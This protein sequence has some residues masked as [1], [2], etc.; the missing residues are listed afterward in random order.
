MKDSET[1]HRNL[2]SGLRGVDAV[3]YQ[4]GA[5]RPCSGDC[6]A[7][8][9]LPPSRNYTL[10]AKDFLPPVISGMGETS[11]Q[12][13]ND[14]NSIDTGRMDFDNIAPQNKIPIIIKG[15]FKELL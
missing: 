10:I 14:A 5:P 15:K 13:E 3:R 8:Q 2:L 7:L 11:Y 1:I 6:Q 4:S 12:D 9:F